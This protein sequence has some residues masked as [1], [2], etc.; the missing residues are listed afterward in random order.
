MILSYLF[1][2]DSEVKIFN[3]TISQPK[4]NFLTRSNY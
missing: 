4:R 1:Q 3:E 2:L